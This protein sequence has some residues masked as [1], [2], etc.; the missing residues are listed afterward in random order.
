[1]RPVATAQDKPQRADGR[2]NRDQ[3]LASAARLFASTGARTTLETVA[4]DAGLGSGTL[5][6][7]FPTRE[8]LV[9]AAYRNAPDA[10]CDAAPTL[11]AEVDGLRTR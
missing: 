3:P 1:L 10:V 2:H 9:E 11:L 5:Y 6:R 7:H 8:A 4:K